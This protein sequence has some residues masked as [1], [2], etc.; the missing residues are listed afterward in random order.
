MN[1]LNAVF[2]LIG[3]MIG[4]LITFI[5]QR[6]QLKKE[7]EMDIYH[8]TIIKKEEAILALKE[9][10][11]LNNK[12]EIHKDEYENYHFF[13]KRYE[14][15]ISSAIYDSIEYLSSDALK[16]FNNL[17]GDLYELEQG[18]TIYEGQKDEKDLTKIYQKL[19]KQIREDLSKLIKTS[20]LSDIYKE[21][22][23]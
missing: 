21:V 12:H 19:I 16:I 15:Y 8:K 7:F 18:L 2:P 22:K 13:H 5:T 14:K 1:I 4:G 20:L 3:V 10:I 17:E 9:I 23:Q 11:I 6:S